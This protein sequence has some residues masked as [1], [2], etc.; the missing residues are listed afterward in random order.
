[1]FV[2]FVDQHVFVVS[3]RRRPHFAAKGVMGC[4]GWGEK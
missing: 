2:D 1:M 4:D 3:D